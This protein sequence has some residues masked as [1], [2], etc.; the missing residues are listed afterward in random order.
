VLFAAAARCDDK[1]DMH[2]CKRISAGEIG[3]HDQ[4]S[5]AIAFAF[6]TVPLSLLRWREAVA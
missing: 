4:S 5:V 2:S 6:P 1:V 3:R